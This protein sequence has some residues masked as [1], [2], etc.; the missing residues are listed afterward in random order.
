MA[1]A[2]WEQQTTLTQPFTEATCRLRLLGSGDR[3]L[4]TQQRR[5]GLDLCFLG[6]HT[7]A[8]GASEFSAG[9]WAGL[10]GDIAYSVTD[11]LSSQTK[12]DNKSQLVLP[13]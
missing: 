1:R 9:R 8:T 7:A 10:S 3:I 12:G 11:L 4:S 5:G 2:N 13:G 6:V